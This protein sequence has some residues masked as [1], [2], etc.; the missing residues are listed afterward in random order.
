[1]AGNRVQA[2]I[3]A[4]RAIIKAGGKNGS[5]DTPEKVAEFDKKQDISFQEHYAYQNAQSVAHATG[6]LTLDEAQIIYQALGEV[7]SEKNGGWAKGT[8]LATKVAV[9]MLMA[10]IL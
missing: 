2:R 6:L 8:D 3:D 4:L 1:M 5:L 10:E 9:T 7:G